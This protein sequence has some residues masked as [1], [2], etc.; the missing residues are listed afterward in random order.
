[1]HR[2]VVGL[3][4]SF[5]AACGG[6]GGDD[7]A[8]APD[9]AP[10]RPVVFGGDRPVQLGVPFD[11]VD[12][13]TY[14]LFLILHGYGV[15]GFTQ[16][17]YL[18]LGALRDVPGAFVLAPDGT[19]DGGGS[20]FWNASGAC[21]DFGGI[22]VD[23]VAYLGGLID[24]V[25][26]A[27]PVDPARVFV[28]G[29]SNGGFMANRLACE[30]ADVVTGIAEM[31]GAGVS[32]DAAACTPS[33]PVNVLHIHGTDDA[34]VR[35]DGGTLVNGADPY[36]GALATTAQWAAD[37]GCGDTFTE[38]TALDLITQTAGA[39]TVPMT[40]DDC[41]AGGTV[42]LWPMDG[43]PHIPTLTN[44]FAPALID[45]LMAHPRP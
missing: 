33:A 31:A 13:Q 37:D 38:G 43:G 7:S 30:R 34:T 17:A 8:P 22:G 11:L 9:A 16:Q 28:V 14:P 23:D 32:I 44:A 1:M 21:C 3:A 42:A 24:D 4:L 29:H 39:E 10:L 27:W 18:G 20:R 6:G 41:P 45:W 15:D 12:G 36:P 35:Y 26:A 19:V 40:Y 5:L 25:M 2:R